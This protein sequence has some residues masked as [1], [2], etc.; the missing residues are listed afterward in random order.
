MHD[1]ILTKRAAFDDIISGTSGSDT[2]LGADLRDYIRGLDGN[3]MLQGGKGGDLLEGWG[4]NDT[5][6]GG[7]GADELRGDGGHDTLIFSPDSGNDLVREFVLPGTSGKAGTSSDTLVLSGMT[8]SD[9]YIVESNT[10]IS[11]WNA[12]NLGTVREHD[13]GPSIII[14]KVGQTLENHDWS[15]T[16]AGVHGH[17]V[18]ELFGL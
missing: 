3:D 11:D 14:L 2:L 17:T 4:G 12:A 15:I 7:L 18:A 13:Y 5:L 16:L 8:P 9:V 6:V 10:A 1:F